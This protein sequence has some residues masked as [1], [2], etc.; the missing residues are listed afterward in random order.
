MGLFRSEIMLNKKIIIPRATYSEIMNEL[1]RLED[2]VEFVDLNKESIQISKNFSKMVLRCDE[3]EKHFNR[4]DR[5]CENHEI[6][7]VKYDN[8]VRFVRDLNRDENA[9][10][11]RLGSTYFDYVE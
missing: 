2:M 7:I 4:F 3:M 9:R 10:N 6:E 11:K 8:Y 1:G 5:I